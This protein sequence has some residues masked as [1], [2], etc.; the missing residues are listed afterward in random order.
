MEAF[1]R[2]GGDAVRVWRRLGQGGERNRDKRK[3]PIKVISNRSRWGGKHVGVH[4]SHDAGRGNGCYQDSRR[5]G[6]ERGTCGGFADMP[7]TSCTRQQ[8]QQQDI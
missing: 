7:A 3:C 5:N 8:Q 4:A 1:G 2:E 6:M